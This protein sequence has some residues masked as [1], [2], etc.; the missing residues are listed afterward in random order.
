MEP[1]E[2]VKHPMR[3]MVV[4][5]SAADRDAL[6]HL[7]KECRYQRFICA[8]ANKHEAKEKLREETI[9]LI[10]LDIELGSSTGFE[11]LKEIE[12]RPK[13]I[14]ASA[15]LKY[16]YDAIE[17]RADGFIQKP[18]KKALYRDIIER[19]YKLWQLDKL[20]HIISSQYSITDEKKRLFVR[21]NGSWYPLKVDSLVFVESDGDYTIVHEENGTVHANLMSLNAMEH[22]LGRKGFAR[23][24]RKYLVNLSKI[25]RLDHTA[26][27]LGI[28]VLPI[29][30]KYKDSFYRS[31]GIK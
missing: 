22:D 25:E 17:E 13:I 6:I 12:R 18:I 8:C 21:S 11:L 14:V 15:H 27:S 30:R 28:A 19:T 10:I 3:T 5:D 26:V 9:D 24:H 2:N 23:I 4:D 1:A 7:A 29:G 20:S 31:I 16:A